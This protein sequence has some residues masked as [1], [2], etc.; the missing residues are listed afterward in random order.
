[1]KR[2]MV[3]LSM[4]M[5]VCVL[6]VNMSRGGGP[7]AGSICTDTDDDCAGKAVTNCAAGNGA[8]KHSAG[9]TCTCEPPPAGA[10]SCYCYGVRN[11]D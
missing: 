3:H 4:C 1:M 7:V 5:A 11:L 8:C 2:F 6:G 9:Y 10:N